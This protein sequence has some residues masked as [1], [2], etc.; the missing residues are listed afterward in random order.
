MGSTLALNAGVGGRVDEDEVEVPRF[1][2]REEREEVQRLRDITPDV[3]S[4][5]AD[6]TL[7]SVV[8]TPPVTS[9]KSDAT[10]IHGS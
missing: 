8:A 9:T 7:L 6:A 4:I 2:F 10:L 5:Y 3:I 1:N